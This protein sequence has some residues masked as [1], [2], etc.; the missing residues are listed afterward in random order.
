MMLQ[1]K[2]MRA[3]PLSLQFTHSEFLDSESFK[4][5]PILDADVVAVRLKYLKSDIFSR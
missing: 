2:S 4:F 5:I 3:R 1:L